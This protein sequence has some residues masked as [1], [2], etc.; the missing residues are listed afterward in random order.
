MNK[1]KLNLS[2][3]ISGILIFRYK[4]QLL[5]LI[6]P[7][8]STKY[9]AELHYE[10]L[11]NEYKF[12]NWISESEIVNILK[13]NNL[14]SDMNERELNT[15]QKQIDQ[16]KIELFKSFYISKKQNSIRARLNY[17]N[18]RY[19][20]FYNIRHSLDHLTVEG[21]CEIYKN[22]QLVLC[23]I[24]LLIMLRKMKNMFLIFFPNKNQSKKNISLSGL[25]F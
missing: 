13:D 25:D 24:A 12:S 14:W 20:K 7:S 3:I 11:Y 8:L 21:F 22:E 15:L 2:R 9:E 18:S 1:E 5:Y 23:F 17:L 16:T 4:D 10:D 6:Y 19:A